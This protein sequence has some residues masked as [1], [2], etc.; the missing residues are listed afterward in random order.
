MNYVGS[1]DRMLRLAE[2]EIC[3]RLHSLG[4]NGDSLRLK[5]YVEDRNL[6]EQHP[7]LNSLLTDSR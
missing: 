5:E 7:S 4:G 2:G 3:G 1:F 6:P